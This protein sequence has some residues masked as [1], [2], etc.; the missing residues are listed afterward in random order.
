M[1]SNSR[2]GHTDSKWQ[3]GDWKPSSLAP[4]PKV[5]VYQ[6][7]VESSGEKWKLGLIEITLEC[8]LCPCDGYEHLK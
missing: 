3:T 6:E 5:K 7:S 4:Q 8:V 2:K 1:L